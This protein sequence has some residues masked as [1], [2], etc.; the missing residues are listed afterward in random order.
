MVIDW[1]NK[2]VFVILRTISREEKQESCFFD[3][4]HEELP[5]AED[6]DCHI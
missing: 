2:F 4:V 1:N 6:V 5:M 3:D